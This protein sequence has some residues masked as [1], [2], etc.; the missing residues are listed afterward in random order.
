M[1][2]INI[3]F[4]TQNTRKY[5]IY[6]I[7]NFIFCKNHN[8]TKQVIHFLNSAAVADGAPRA[9]RFT[10]GKILI[11]TDWTEMLFMGATVPD[12]YIADNLRTLKK[13]RVGRS[14]PRVIKRRPK[15]FPRQ[16]EPRESL[17]KKL[18]ADYAMKLCV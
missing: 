2:K 3:L 11:A 12:A 16:Q 17:R 1:V 10:A 8:I 9:I 5:G 15:A 14:E 4:F 6:R 13:H 7:L 18:V